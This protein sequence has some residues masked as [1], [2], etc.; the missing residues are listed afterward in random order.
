[1]NIKEIK[2]QLPTGTIKKIAE[3]TGLHISTINRFFNGIKVKNETELLIINTT[4]EF[5]KNK[6]AEKKTALQELQ[7]VAKL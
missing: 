5:L 4:T 6:K 2:K 3:K 7:D 1:M